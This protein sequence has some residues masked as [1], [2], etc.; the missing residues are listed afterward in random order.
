MVLHHR[1]LPGARLHRRS[2]ERGKTAPHLDRVRAKCSARH[3]LTRRKSESSCPLASAANSVSKRAFGCDPHVLYC[4]ASK[5]PAK[6]P[7]AFRA[8]WQNRIRAMTDEIDVPTTH[9]AAKQSSILAQLRCR[10]RRDEGR[11]QTFRGFELLCVSGEHAGNRFFK[12]LCHDTRES[13]SA[14]LGQRRAGRFRIPAR[15][16]RRAD[17]SRICEGEA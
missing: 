9:Q 10:C 17:E 5:H 4:S 6:V 15:F 14:R 2:R 13:N 7:L 8:F 3:R 12:W 11:N 1:M 16:R